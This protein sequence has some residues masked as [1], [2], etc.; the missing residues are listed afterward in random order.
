V[1]PEVPELTPAGLPSV[2]DDEAL[3]IPDSVLVSVAGETGL[4]EE[5]EAPTPVDDTSVGDALPEPA[6]DTS[7][8]DAAPDVGISVPAVWL[9]VVPVYGDN[10]P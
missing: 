3:A 5:E 1:K 2:W 4:V 6:V 9:A 7:E 8:G 10:G